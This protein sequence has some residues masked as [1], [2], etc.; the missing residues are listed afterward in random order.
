MKRPRQLLRGTTGR[1]SATLIM[2]AGFTGVHAAEIDV[3][4]PD[5]TVRFD[6][7]VKY[8][9]AARLKSVNSEV[10]AGPGASNPNPN[11]DDGDRNF[12]NKGV[13]SSRL[14]LLSELDAKYKNVGLRVSAAAWYDS[15]YNR[16]NKNDSPATV[17]SLSAG[18]DEF[19][20][21]T[22]K[23][24]GRKAEFLDAFVYGKASF[25]DT[26]VN[27]RAGRFT[28]LYGE[29]LF[30]G[31]NGVAAAQA[32][33]DIIKLLSVPNS[34]FKEIL[35]PVEQLS[36]S[37]QLSKDLSIGAYYQWKWDKARLP[38]AGSY[39]SFADFAD[40]GGERLIFGAPPPGFGGPLAFFRGHDLKARDAGEFGGQ[41]RYK[42]ANYEFGL[43]AAQYHDKLPQFY[44]RPS[45]APNQATGQIGEYVLV[46]AEKIRA[47]GA[48]VSTVI[49]ET[50]V[51]AEVSI[52]KNTPLN[53]AG[54]VILD[55][56]GT[57]D[58]RSNPLYPI[59]S[60]F[61]AQ[62]SAISVLPAN[63][64]WAGASFIGEVAF[65]RRLSV[66]R[67]ADQ[68]DPNTD[69]DA[70][71]LRFVF[72]P[73]YF[74]V[75]PQVD[76]QVPIGIG[77]GIKGVSSVMR[78]GVFPAERGGDVSVGVNF[79]YAKKWTGSLS[80][81]HYFGRTGAVVNSQLQ[82]SGDQ[83]LKDRDFV[84]FSLQRTF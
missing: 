74:Q 71:A 9:T 57:G 61:H 21:A 55:V 72:Q 64:L 45:A 49:G 42:L 46:Y 28:Q 4:N 40:A 70:A 19:V 34:Q 68:L 54:N 32:T 2:I 10:A 56:T 8:S 52:R 81:T 73:E 25:G 44:L 43:Y 35:R 36:G 63:A 67:N 27:V 77:Y 41:V 22:E 29:S 47:Y 39:F 11:L 3:G 12:S 66:S 80:F 79:D 50:N 20:S 82:L 17:N 58:G 16:R 69:R 14:D 6:N 24:H 26:N 38:A 18:P 78:P 1:A 62:V 65:N 23:L 83:Y 76:I 7:T 15:V 30:F 53:A 37:V 84:A 75:L 48:S 13:I 51:A 33:V 31:A 5:L 59:G 60:S